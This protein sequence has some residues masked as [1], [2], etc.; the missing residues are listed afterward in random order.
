[1]RMIDGAVLQISYSGVAEE[2]TGHR[3]A[4]LPAPDLMPYVTDPELY[5]RDAPF[6]DIVGEQVFPVP[7]RFDYDARPGVHQDVSHPISHLTLG[8][9]RHCR[10]PV[11]RGV[12]PASFVSFVINSFY[13][14]LDAK[15]LSFPRRVSGWLESI[16][17]A[18]REIPHFVHP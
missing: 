3:L 7:L 10:I 6:L 1:M 16:S 5:V 4:Y 18:E 17:V 2:L 12:S 15:R 9:Y 14:P 13:T 11:T 8:Q